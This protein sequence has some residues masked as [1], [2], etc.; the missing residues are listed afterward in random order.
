MKIR[1]LTTSTISL[2]RTSSRFEADLSDDHP[3][4]AIYDCFRG[5]VTE[6]V[7]TLLEENNIHVVVV[8]ANCTGRLQP[9]DLS[10]NKAVKDFLRREFQ[11]WYSEKILSQLDEV[12]TPDSMQLQPVSLTGASV[13][14]TSASWLVRMFDYIHSNPQLIVNGFIEEGIPQAIDCSNN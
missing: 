1:Q 3:A 8:P 9:L 7:S 11:I 12:D 2:C 4:L 6:S 13:K 5:Q 10:L 14:S